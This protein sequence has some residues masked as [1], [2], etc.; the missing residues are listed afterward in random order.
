MTRTGHR[1]R[2]LVLPS[3]RE[4]LVTAKY[5]RDGRGEPV[6]AVVLGLR[7]ADGR[8]RAEN[9]GAA[10]LTDRGPRAAVPAHRGQGLL[11]DPPAELG[12]VHR[13]PEAPHARDDRG[14]RRPG[15]PPHHRAARRLADRRRPADRPRPAARPRPRL[16]A[17]VERRVVARRWTAS[18]SSSTSPTTSARCGP[19]R[20]ASSRWSPT[21]S[22]TP[23]ATATARCA[24]RRGARSSMAGP[25][26]TSSSAT[27]ARASPRST[28]SSSSPGSGRAGPSTARASGLYLVRGLV[29]AHGGVVRVEDAP[30]GGP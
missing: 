30:G 19:T 22:R 12:P 20:T 1:E 5:V 9:E 27:T 25:P 11:L 10:L 18:S 14:R 13:R 7:D 29:E 2:L 17:Q 6:R 23:C 15:H 21:S 4:V 8:R 3:G 24:S 16:E 28:A 26:S